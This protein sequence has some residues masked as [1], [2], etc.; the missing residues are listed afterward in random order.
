MLLKAEPL[1]KYI[2]S[3]LKAFKC[4]DAEGWIRSSERL[5]W[6]K[7]I[8]LSQGKKNKKYETKKG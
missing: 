6:K 8:T 5:V 1:G 7:I 3:R 2:S 4:G